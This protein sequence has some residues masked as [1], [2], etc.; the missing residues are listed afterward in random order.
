MDNNRNLLIIGAGQYGCVAKEVA[1]AMGCFA[2]IDFLD[3]NHPAAMGK[4][5]D[6]LAL[7][8]RY[9]NA[10]VALGNPQ[11][12]QSWIEK[13]VRAGYRIPVLVH[14]KAYVS[15][16]AELFQ[17]TIVEPMAVVQANAVVKAG[18]LLC[19]G[20][21]VNHNAVVEP[22]CQ[23]DCNAVVASNAIVPAGTKVPCGTVYK[24][25]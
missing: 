5:A 11:L 13:L 14:P 25:T 21:V 9:G 23:I 6:Y 18:G 12:R 24:K 20:C 2:R 22:G 8:D 7:A 15:P 3:D 4:M 1:Q 16:S 10:A 19:A 17:G